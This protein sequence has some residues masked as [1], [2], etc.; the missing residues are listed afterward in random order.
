MKNARRNTAIATVALLT[1]VFSWF[2]LRDY[3]GRRACEGRGAAFKAQVESIKRDAHEQLKKGTRKADFA[4]FFAEHNIPFD[5]FA[6]EA[7]G[8]LYT[9]GC[10]PFGCGPDSAL[11]GVS[12]QL[13][14]AGTATDEPKVVSLYTDCL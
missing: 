13:N 8:T 2:G 11:I 9:T 1:A 3:R 4:R 7:R 6:T 5:F 12:V 14:S 10:A